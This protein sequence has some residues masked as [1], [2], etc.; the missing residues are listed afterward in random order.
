MIQTASYFDATEK[1]GYSDL[2]VMSSSAG[3]YV[4]TSFRNTEIPGMVF[5]EPGSRDTDY[6]A[7]EA[8]AAD[9]L[10]RLGAGEDLPIRLMP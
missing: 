7:T 9:F 4:G 10:K 8:E 2:K 1:S 6:F 5:D 3:W